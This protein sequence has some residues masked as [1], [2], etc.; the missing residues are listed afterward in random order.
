[1]SDFLCPL[2]V[3][4]G[5]GDVGL[6]VAVYGAFGYPEI[7]RYFPQRGP[8]DESWARPSNRIPRG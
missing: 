6:G 8:P 1:M 2:G 3:L 7:S 4:E 5:L